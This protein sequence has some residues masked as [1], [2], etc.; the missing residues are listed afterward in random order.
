[1]AIKRKA[2]ILV[3][4][5][6]VITVVTALTMPVSAVVTNEKN[7]G[8]IFNSDLL[9]RMPLEIQRS[10]IST[11]AMSGN[12]KL[13]PGGPTDEF[14]PDITRD[15]NGNIIVTFTQE[16]SP[17]DGL[18]HI[19]Y[20]S[21]GENWNDLA[22]TGL[23]G[24]NVYCQVAYMED[25]KYDTGVF[26]GVWWDCIDESRDAGYFIK[27]GDI[28]DDSTW[29]GYQWVDDSRPGASCLVWK[30]D[31][32][33]QQVS[34]GQSSGPVCGMIDDDQGMDQGTM[35]YWMDD[36]ITGIVSNWDSGTGPLGDYFP[37]SDIDL[38]PVHD[39]NPV[40][41]ENDF[42]YMVHQS[43]RGD[44]S[45][46]CWKRV[47]PNVE[48]DQ[49]FV[50][51]QLYLDGGDANGYN[52]RHPVV[53]ASGDKVMVIYMSDENGDWDIK[54][55]YSSDHGV[56]WNSKM[57]AAESGVDELYPSFY[58]EGDNIHCIYIKNGNL[59]LIE[60]DDFGATWSDP[61]QINEV[62]GTVVAEV[63][64]A[65]IHPAGIVWT[66]E[67][68]GNKDIYY[69]QGAPAP[70]LSVEKIQ[71]GVGATATITNTGTAPATNVQWTISLNGLVFLGGEKTGTI[72]TI[73]PGESVK[74]K[75]G[76]PLGFGPVDVTVSV[77]SAEGVSASKTASGTLLLFYLKI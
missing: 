69:A 2:K 47:V 64:S 14:L 13:S 21:D 61:V 35:L 38:A 45:E 53:G 59:Y 5:A 20:S 25:T 58:M 1:M 65:V 48:D 67:R 71:G 49:E 32:L 17:T 10:S 62:D 55:K 29:E 72:S 12:I 22:L 23:E 77:Q 30:D 16:L 40:Q 57:I 63:N 68:N 42:F 28:T 60:S 76:F 11:L 24:Y 26:D 41:T 19:V 50:A 52:A 36:D 4:A 15:G 56:T 8:S 75:S 7:P 66:D 9:R 3:E 46:V 34:Y 27:I 39:T 31:M 37:A 33:Y 73:A 18:A 54:C 6:V 43:D 74:V 51:D 44:Y 70:F